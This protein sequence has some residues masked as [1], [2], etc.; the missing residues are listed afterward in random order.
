MK[1]NDVPE[2][3]TGVHPPFRPGILARAGSPVILSPR[4]K[5]DTDPNDTIF[6]IVR[7]RMS[8]MQLLYGGQTG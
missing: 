7:V 6:R 1:A 5:G 8:L 4:P 3:V 2:S